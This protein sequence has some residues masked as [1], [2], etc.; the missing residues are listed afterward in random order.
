MFGTLCAAHGPRLASARSMAR[1]VAAPMLVA[2]VMMLVTSGTAYA[3]VNWEYKNLQSGCKAYIAP[4]KYPDGVNGATAEFLGF[5]W[6]S[7][8]QETRRL[9]AGSSDYMLVRDDRVRNLAYQYF[10]GDDVGII[11]ETLETIGNTMVRTWTKLFGNEQV[12]VAECTW[13]EYQ[14]ARQ[15]F[16][17]Y[18][19]ANDGTT[20]DE[21]GGSG[22]G[23]GGTESGG[24]LYFTYN[25]V[26]DESNNVSNVGGVAFTQ[27]QWETVQEYLAANLSGAGLF[28][29]VG[30]MVGNVNN[31]GFDC[32]FVN[33]MP[34]IADLNVYWP[35]VRR[36]HTVYVTYG[37][38]SSWVEFNGKKYYK[39]TDGN[40]QTLCR[41]QSN[42][43]EV[44]SIVR[45]LAG[46]YWYG[47]GESGGG[48]EQN[49]YV[50]TPD[51][52]PTR[53]IIQIGDVTVD[54][55]NGPYTVNNTTY[56]VVYAPDNSWS[57]NVETHTDDPYDG[58]I[59]AADPTDYTSILN[60]ILQAINKFR[61]EFNT[62][63]NDIDADL[64]T[65]TNSVNASLKNVETTLKNQLVALQNQIHDDIQTLQTN[66]QNNFNGKFDA[67]ATRLW[68][69]LAAMDQDLLEELYK[70]AQYIVDNMN[71]NADYDDSG[72]VS[73]LKRIYIRL[74]GKKVTI[75]SPDEDTDG[76]VDAVVEFL[77][78]ILG[79]MVTG[80]DV[81]ELARMMN[82]LKTRFPISI[83]WD[84]VAILYLFD[85]E[86]VTPVVDFPVYNGDELV[87][88]FHCDMSQWDDEMEY[89][90]QGELLL[91]A[92]A[93]MFN[94]KW[95]MSVEEEVIRGKE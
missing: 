95:L 3:E 91:F 90:R 60:A 26:V 80:L 29:A 71:F 78:K 24:L 20:G 68:S 49:P 88:Q 46:Y 27:E 75:P 5:D 14:N 42:S 6:D 79:M 21:G 41:I 73:W 58:D 94:T 70:D 83:P 31:T 76:W 2:L 66:L 87:T 33:T 36:T 7:L 74:G 15:I 17:K 55:S 61:A 69:N 11:G 10:A 32:G 85:G 48:S 81:A 28:F 38:N 53:P 39:M 82:D 18:A 89:V 63:Y 23:S 64:T 37:N 51:D 54:L 57:I 30:G 34:R 45:P 77:Q 67:F 19:Y 35:G 9:I 92:L 1:L 40:V 4:Y 93:L 16:L 65:L 52:D 12:W 50:P 13:D 22:G 56:S 84:I 62:A 25:E 72:I 44:W 43:N 59:V 8:S 86:P 47:D